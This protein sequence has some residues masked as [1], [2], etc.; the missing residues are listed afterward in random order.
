MLKSAVKMPSRKSRRESFC[1]RIDSGSLSQIVA[2]ERQHIE[3]VELHFLVVPARVQRV[4]VGDAVGAE[5]HGF[6]VD[7]D[8][9]C[10]FLRAASTIPDLLED[11][12][13]RSNGSYRLVG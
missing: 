13:G 2:V 3:G 11:D 8:C 5:H 10:R 7:H 4:E 1:L 6:A 12:V 9:L